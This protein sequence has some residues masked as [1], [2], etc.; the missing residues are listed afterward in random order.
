[1]SLPEI[2]QDAYQSDLRLAL[3][4]YLFMEHHASLQEHLLR[5]QF[6]S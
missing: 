5:F 2:G 1:M 6:T 3:E 4:E